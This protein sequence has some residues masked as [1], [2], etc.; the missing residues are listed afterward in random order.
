MSIEELFNEVRED[1][2]L[3]KIDISN[4][5]Y[6]TMKLQGKYLQKLTEEKI[7]FESAKA[8]Y[9]V[10]YRQKY[11]YYLGRANPEE[12]K[13]NPLGLKIMKTEIDTY[14]NGDEELTRQRLR[15]E[16]QK[17]RVQFLEGVLKA[18][19]SR[20]W[21]IKNIIDWKRYLSGG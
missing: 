20:T 18:L 15:M 7:A 14:L 4:S 3:D 8:R 2:I 13:K 19:N 16:S 10:S 5:S 12:Y 11:D 17:I 6:D 9:N 1:L 21:E